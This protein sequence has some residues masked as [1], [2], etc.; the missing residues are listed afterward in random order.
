MDELLQKLEELKI[1][2]KVNEENLDIFDPNFALTDE[3]LS[4]IK[5]YKSVFVKI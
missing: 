4:L 3:L 2:I 5:E 1:T